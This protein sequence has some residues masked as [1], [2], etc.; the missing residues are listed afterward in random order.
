VVL[1]GDPAKKLLTARKSQKEEIETPGMG[2]MRSPP[3]TQGG[4]G[5]GK[6]RWREKSVIPTSRKNEQ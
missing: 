2:Q 5:G 6:P 4:K 3:I 1:K